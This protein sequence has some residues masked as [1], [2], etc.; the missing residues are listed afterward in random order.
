MLLFKSFIEKHRNKSADYGWA[1]TK[2]V[3]KK[4]NEKKITLKCSVDCTELRVRIAVAILSS[5]LSVSD[6]DETVS[7]LLQIVLLP[8]LRLFFFL[9][10]IIILLKCFFF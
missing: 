8:H 3:I 1:T 7:K 9:F 2:K 6:G 5:F 4:K 10:F